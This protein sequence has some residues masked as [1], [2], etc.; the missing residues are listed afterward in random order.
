LFFLNFNDAKGTHDVML[1]H[2][3][4]FFRWGMVFFNGI[5]FVL[6]QFWC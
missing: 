5:F 3:N 2:S 6:L 4:Y 1:Q